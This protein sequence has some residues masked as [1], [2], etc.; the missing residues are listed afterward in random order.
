MATHSVTGK[1][2]MIEGELT[3][4]ASDREGRGRWSHFRVAVQ[5]EGEFSRNRSFRWHAITMDRDE[6]QR[7]V[8]YLTDKLAYG[9]RGI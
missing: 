3:F 8:D 9:P 2:D 4:S 6:A 1:R 5:E 7:L